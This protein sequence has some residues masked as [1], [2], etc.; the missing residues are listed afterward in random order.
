MTFTFR[1]P[2]ELSGQGCLGS[3][4][5]RIIAGSGFSLFWAQFPAFVEIQKTIEIRKA[6]GVKQN[7]EFC[8]DK[9]PCPSY[10]AD[11][12]GRRKIEYVTEMGMKMKM[13][14]KIDHSIK[15]Q[16]QNQNQNDEF[17]NIETSCGCL[18]IHDQKILK[19]ITDGIDK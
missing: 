4:F 10:I 3:S 13:K 18:H 15:N 2:E 9:R 1:F 19:I 16:N 11:E 14:M 17:T 12:K 5:L 6:E 8:S 7:N